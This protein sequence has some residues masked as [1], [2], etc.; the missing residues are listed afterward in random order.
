MPMV[1][2]EPVPTLPDA[3]QFWVYV[4]GEQR[5]AV[6]YFEWKVRGD[7][8]RARQRVARTAC[9]EAA[10]VQR[11]PVWRT[12]SGCGGAVEVALR[13]YEPTSGVLTLGLLLAERVFVELAHPS[14]VPRRANAAF[15]ALMR[16]L[17]GLPGREYEFRPFGPLDVEAVYGR[18]TEQR[19]R[20]AAE[21]SDEPL[22][23]DPQHPQLL[24][25]LRPYQRA[26]VAWMLRREHRPPADPAQLHQLYVPLPLGG[27]TVYYCPLGGWVVRER[28]AAV[29]SPPGG[30]L[31]D[32]MGLGKTVEIL[33]LVLTHTRQ[34]VEKVEP[35]EPVD[36]LAYEASVKLEEASKRRR[37]PKRTW[38]P[39]DSEDDTPAGMGGQAEGRAA[40]RASRSAVN[41]G[42]PGERPTRQSWASG[43]EADASSDD[44]DDVVYVAPTVS[45][46]ERLKRRQALLGEPDK[47]RVEAARAAASPVT[48]QPRQKATAKPCSGIPDD[49]TVANCIEDVIVRECY[50]GAAPKD[51]V[52]G[53]GLLPHWAEFSERLMGSGSDS[54]PEADAAKQEKAKA[55]PEEADSVAD[56]IEDVIVRLC[57]NGRPPARHRRGVGVVRAPRGR[58]SKAPPSDTKRLAQLH[59]EN[60]LAE[61][62]PLCAR[63]PAEEVD[64]SFS[65]LC[66]RWRDRR[67]RVQCGACDTFQHAACVDYKVEDP[68]RGPYWCPQCWTRRPPVRSGA[69]L[70]VSP[71]SICD[72]WVQEIG[73]HIRREGLR[74]L[75]YAGVRSDRYIQPQTLAS[76]DLVVTTY[77]VLQRELNYAA[78]GRAGGQAGKRRVQ[79]YLPPPT[80]LLCV[81]WWRVCLDE[82]QM[83]EC[84]TSRTAEMA[85]KLSCVNRWCVTG[86][87]LSRSVG[88]L[89][90]LLLFL[91]VDPVWCELWWN[92][93][94]YYPYL[95][96][97]L[98]PLDRLLERCLWRTAK[99]D[100]LDQIEV[101]EQSERL[102]LL[103][104]SPVESYFYRRQHEECSRAALARLAALGDDSLQ[105]HDIERSAVNQL[106]HPLLRLRQACCHPQVVRGQFMPLHKSTMTMEQLLEQLIRR[107]T[108]EA[109]EAHRQRT[110]AVHGLAA[111]HVERA[112]WEA[113]ADLYRTVLRQADELRDRL[114]T[115][116]LQRLHAL[117]NL[118]ELV[119]AGRPI[120]PTT[121]DHRLRAEAAELR[122]AYVGRHSAAQLRDLSNADGNAEKQ[123]DTGVTKRTTTLKGRTPPNT[124]IGRFSSASGLQCLLVARLSQ[125]AELRAQTQEAVAALAALE[126][127]CLVEAAIDCHLRPSGGAADHC[128]LCAAHD[129]FPLYERELFYMVQGR[130]DGGEL[131]GVE[132]KISVLGELQRG[133]WGDNETERVLKTLLATARQLGMGQE[134]L[135]L[136][137]HHIKMLEAMKKEFKSLRVLWM[138]LNDRVSASDEL[139]MCVLRLRARFADEPAPDL[140]VSRGGQQ[141]PTY[142]IERH[143]VEAHMGRLRAERAVA[144]SELRRKLGQCLYLQNLQRS[145]TD[146][147]DG[148]PDSCPICENTL[149]D[150]WSVLQCGHC[151][152]MTCVQR[153]V[154]EFSLGGRRGRLK[155]AI[156]RELTRH[157]DIAYVNADRAAP[158]GDPVQVSGS[159]S[160]KVEAV[161]RCVL[162]V[163]R[164][165]PAAKLLV[166]ATW[167]DALDLIAAALDQNG[168]QHRS[169]HAPNRFQRSLREFRG[170]DDVSVLLLPVHSG[171]NGLNLTE[172]THVILTHPVLDPGAERQA[173]GRVHR[174]GQR[175]ATVVHR[176][177]VRDTIEERVLALN[178][179]RPAAHAAGQAER[180]LTLADL[181]ELFRD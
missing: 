41:G 116:M 22:P 119:A 42:A 84:P 28:P 109:E 124:M 59:Y 171:A 79:R 13:H 177:V 146:F 137:T 62:S 61:M 55:K 53:L 170:R 144:E 114:Q 76:H 130:V 145:G 69:T 25:R 39:S 87:P 63:P 72:Q 94:V 147:R 81:D 96:G 11:E 97:E 112:E 106:L 17:F 66:G 134:V 23:P 40:R 20:A 52:R 179:G 68:L 91:G 78:V 15:R 88:D 86:T 104:F 29:S 122:A 139:E 126:P 34:D 60:V 1:L 151:F 64:P 57:Y 154:E 166:F 98:A 75:V 103:D 111:L 108:A 73:K 99:A 71:S 80:P 77:T 33:S 70:I 24:P 164:D 101:P 163:L 172:A 127:T 92:Q 132:G 161:V 35:R 27:A 89:Y 85:L 48:P 167:T 82:A 19:Q 150:R 121:R 136:G 45:R 3:D 165:E 141:L 67:Y 159:H 160:T 173:V 143:E 9:L 169:L 174:I 38:S 8:T 51:Y 7:G 49:D 115:D 100:V 158:A 148:N 175:R 54:S 90:G 118:A 47:P 105:L 31:A 14:E 50:G 44:D 152:C 65:C 142:V 43:G 113:A 138:R 117:H 153:L 37:R 56:A 162:T 18:L 21:P 10:A 156:C 129:T 131:S 176:L 157:A 123:V 32:E 83:V 102:V 2:A 128:R 181:R 16:Q 125:L 133:N 95:H 135:Q 58:R 110:A 93:C 12:L 140:P 155:C 46:G 26:A 5:R 178:A 107:A 6:L 30:I 74:V 120:P 149:G 180:G 168:V 4:S 36:L